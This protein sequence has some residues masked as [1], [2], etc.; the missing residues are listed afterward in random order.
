LVV[1]SLDVSSAVTRAPALRKPLHAQQSISLTASSE[2]NPEGRRLSLLGAA[3][4]LRTVV[5]AAS[6]SSSGRLPRGVLC[7]ATI[8]AAVISITAVSA[9]LFGVNLLLWLRSVLLPGVEAYSLALAAHPLTTKLVTAATLAF[10]GDAIA[11]RAKADDAPYDRA[12]AASFVM[13]DTAYRGGFQHVAFPWI[14]AVCRGHVL[15][16]LIKEKSLAAA[17]ECTAFNQLLVVPIIYYP[18]FFGITGAVQGL[19]TTESL[20]RARTS[21]ATLTLRNWKFW[22]PAQI[23]QFACLAPKWQVPY[24][25]VMG[26]VWNIILSGAAGAARPAADAPATSKRRTD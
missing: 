7:T 1:A 8:S 13:F 18:L 17:F 9:A 11:Q 25:C 26:L 22:I 19:T 12:R 5:L 2:V 20:K 21:F 23:V 24:T 6:S 14:I 4:K 3:T 15:G 16:G 10:A